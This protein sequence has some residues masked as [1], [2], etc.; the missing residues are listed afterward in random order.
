MRTPCRENKSIL[1]ALYRLA[2]VNLNWLA[3]SND[4][5]NKRKIG[6]TCTGPLVL[7]KDGVPLLLLSVSVISYTT[8]CALQQ[9]GYT[10]SFYKFILFIHGFSISLDAFE[11]RCYINQLACI[12]RS[13][14]RI[15]WTTKRQRRIPL[16]Y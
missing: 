4:K 13:D 7:N 9:S 2:S 8:P 16:P 3:R 14:F 6:C 12:I 11:G 5:N 10:P 1:C 15:K